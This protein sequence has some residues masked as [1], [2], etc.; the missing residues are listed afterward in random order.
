MSEAVLPSS[1]I[2]K[3]VLDLFAHFSN[4]CT[5][6]LRRTMSP[7]LRLDQLIRYETPLSVRVL[8]LSF[9][10]HDIETKPEQSVRNFLPLLTSQAKACWLYGTLRPYQFLAR[11]M[12]LAR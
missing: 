7:G 8:R 10:A 4:S 12:T 2:Q 6:P 5:W 1:Y 3:L 11:A 9:S